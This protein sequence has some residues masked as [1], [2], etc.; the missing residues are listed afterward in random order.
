MESGSVLASNAELFSSA[1]LTKRSKSVFNNSGCDFERL[2]LSDFETCIQKINE[3]VIFEQSDRYFNNVIL[4]GDP[5]AFYLNPLFQL[6]VDGIEFKEPIKESIRNKRFKN[7]NTLSGF[8][9]EEYSG[10]LKSILGLKDQPVINLTEIRKVLNDF[11]PYFP[12]YPDK[13]SVNFTDNVINLYTKNSSIT[14]Y[15]KTLIQILSEEFYICPQIHLAQIYSESNEAY[16]F[17]FERINPSNGL[18][19]WYGAVHGS[20]MPYVYGSPLAKTNALIFSDNDRELSKKMIF[21]W[22]NFVKYGNPNGNST[23]QYTDPYWPP[24]SK[25]QNHIIMDNTT[26]RIATS[27]TYQG[28]LRQLDFWRTYENF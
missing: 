4:K 26:V 11:Y 3:S 25:I 27:F 20:E 2:Q 5:Y 7:V 6:V 15:F 18:P 8:N 9:S 14:D 17:S 19:K 22:T 12:R 1:E 10:F 28:N 21:Y 24:M 16:V 23:K 13:P